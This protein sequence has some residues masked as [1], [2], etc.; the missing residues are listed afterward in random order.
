MRTAEFT[1]SAARV[2]VDVKS[3]T[4]R[5][6]S[7]MSRSVHIVETKT[8]RQLLGESGVWNYLTKE[9]AELLGFKEVQ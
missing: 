9:W 2:D 8:G 5:L 1:G 4:L 7:D 3:Q 6:T